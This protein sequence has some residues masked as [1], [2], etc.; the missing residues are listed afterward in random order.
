M[1]ETDRGEVAIED[2][3]TDTDRIN[4]RKIIGITRTVTNK[5]HLVCIA[6][7][8]LGANV[9]S[10]TTV[11]S[12]DHLIMYKGRMIKSKNFVGKFSG[13]EK[14]KY[15]GQ[16]LYNVLLMK[17]GIMM[18]NNMRCET[19]NPSSDIAKYY[20]ALYQGNNMEEIIEN[21]EALDYESTGKALQIK[22]IMSNNRK[23]SMMVTRSPQK[24]MARKKNI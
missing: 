17:E 11:V 9:P 13:V 18:A 20:K 1:I 2:L 3:S 23:G 10:R 22:M 8:A 24:K 19:L 7:D 14:E 4:G 6:E 16:T 12:E 5:S 21:I 15:L